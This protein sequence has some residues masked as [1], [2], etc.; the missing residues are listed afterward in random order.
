MFFPDTKGAKV[1]RDKIEWLNK[2]SVIVLTMYL[3]K[4]APKIVIV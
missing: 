4:H 2:K 3:N 1:V